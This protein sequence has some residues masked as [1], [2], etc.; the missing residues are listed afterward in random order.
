MI[1]R[2]LLWCWTSQHSWRSVLLVQAKQ[3]R[4]LLEEERKVKQEKVE[5]IKE[6]VKKVLEDMH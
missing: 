3:R 1:L 4:E 2:P 5:V 6:A